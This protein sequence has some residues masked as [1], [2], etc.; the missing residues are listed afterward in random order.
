MEQTSAPTSPEPWR[1]ARAVPVPPLLTAA[2]CG[3]AGTITFAVRP[4]AR[5]VGPN[6]PTGSV[7]SLG[8]EPFPTVSH[9]RP[10]SPP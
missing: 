4:L 7:A 1:D 2:S 10:G 3:P 8:F 6:R 5:D 9:Q